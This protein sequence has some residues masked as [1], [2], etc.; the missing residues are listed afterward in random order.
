MFPKL[1]AI[2]MTLVIAGGALLVARHR[3]L[4]AMHSITQE[5]KQLERQR[6]LNRAL[7]AQVAG[8]IAELSMPDPASLPRAV[9]PDA[10]PLDEPMPGLTP[11]EELERAARVLAGANGAA[12]PGAVPPL[13]GP[14]PDPSPNAAAE[15]AR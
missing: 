8:R 11:D 15:P 13:R 12:T 1:I 6:T 7:N 4:E 5:L 10:S 3:R 9:D 2:V 14:V